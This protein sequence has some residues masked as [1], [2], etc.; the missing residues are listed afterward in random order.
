M[1]DP[2]ADRQG[3]PRTA[4]K[5]RSVCCTSAGYRVIFVVVELIFLVG[6][7]STYGA[8][9]WTWTSAALIASSVLGLAGVLQGVVRRIE[10]ADDTLCVTDLWTRY[11]LSKSEIVSV[12][13]AKGVPTTLL[14]A[15]G[16]KISLPELGQRPGN[17]IRAWLKRAS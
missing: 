10:L 16:R 6:A 7:V 9:G 3:R 1:L 15:D 17:S 13:E 2:Q 12:H 4:Y 14:L 8:R 11:R 5:G